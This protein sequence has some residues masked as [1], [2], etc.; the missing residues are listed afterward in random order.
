MH[1]KWI[2]AKSNIPITKSTR[3]FFGFLFISFKSMELNWMFLYKILESN[4]DHPISLQS[5]HFFLHY[6]EWIISFLKRNSEEIFIFEASAIKINLKISLKFMTLFFLSNW[7]KIQS[8]AFVW[9]WITVSPKTIKKE[10]KKKHKRKL[11]KDAFI[12]FHTSEVSKHC[13]LNKF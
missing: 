13:L 1:L 9:R 8:I 7:L 10:K 5:I 11:W 4:F 6:I 12:V 3:Y 2:F